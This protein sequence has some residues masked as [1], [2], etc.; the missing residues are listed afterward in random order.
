MS[1]N[2]KIALG[3]I[4][5]L[6]ISCICICGISFFLLQSAGTLM[7]QSLVTDPAQVS[8]IGSKIAQYELPAGYSQNFG[9]SL[10]GFD[11]VG[12]TA[13]EDE[14]KAPLI[15]MMQFPTWA[16]MDEAQ[17]EQQLQQSIGQ[18]IGNQD[19]QLQVV[20]QATAT[21]RDQPVTLTTRE[22]TNSEG[23]SLRQVTGVFQGQGGPVLLMILGNTQTWDQAA[24][25]RFIASIR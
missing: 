11:L 18:Q 16:N 1:R 7:E 22:G 15:F 4:G 25:D 13:G 6:V 20:D 9:M 23:Q 14:S 5:L 10:F 12:L 2:T 17:M 24:I 3:I 8:N 21:I 19:L